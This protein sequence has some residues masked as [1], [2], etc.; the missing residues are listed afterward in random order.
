MIQN[1]FE[2]PG[3]AKFEWSPS[4]FF[5]GCNRTCA[6]PKEH[7]MLDDKVK[8]RCP[9]CKR[10]FREKARRVRDGAQANC[11]ECCKLITISKETDDP[12]IRRALKAA[13]E[14]RAAQE[15]QLVATVYTSAASARLRETS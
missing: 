8:I 6:Y 14:I 4:D 3:W 7:P 9:G 5:N 13:K 15:A 11:P 10:I 12:F 1:L 2:N